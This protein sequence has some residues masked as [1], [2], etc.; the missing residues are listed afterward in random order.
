MF[1]SRRRVVW[2]ECSARLFNPRVLTVLNARQHCSFRCA[3]TLQL[4]CDDH[5]QNLLQLLEKL[6]KKSFRSLRGSRRLCTRMSSTLPSWSTARQRECL[7]PPIM[8]KTHGLHA[9]CHHNAGDDDGVHSRTSVRTRTTPWSNRFIA[10]D[11]SPLFQKLFHI[12]LNGAKSE[13]TTTPRGSPFQAGSGTLCR[14]GEWCLFSGSYFSILFSYI[15]KLTLSSRACC[16]FIAQKMPKYRDSLFIRK[17]APG[18]F[19]LLFI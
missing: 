15:A 2:W 1:F 19:F 11:H 14:W 4:I 16:T 3:I 13:K 10:H 17:L 8:R 12:T 5:A 7:S 18:V 6:A 9:I